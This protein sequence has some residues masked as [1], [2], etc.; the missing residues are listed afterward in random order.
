MILVP[1]KHQGEIESEIKSL[2]GHDARIASTTFEFLSIPMDEQTGTA[3]SLFS[4][5]H[6]II[7]DCIILSCDVVTN[8]PILNMINVYRRHDPSLVSL[9]C[10][11]NPTTM[12]RCFGSSKSGR[13]EKD[14]IG[15][16]DSEIHGCATSITCELEKQ[17][18]MVFFSSE[19]D[20]GQSIPFSRDMI[21]KCHDL[22][23]HSSYFDAHAYIFRKNVLD[24]L[25]KE[26]NIGSIKGEFIP[27][28]VQKQFQEEGEESVDN[29]SLFDK[30]ALSFDIGCSGLFFTRREGSSINCIANIIQTTNYSNTSS[31][32]SSSEV[33]PSIF[34]L[35]S[36]SLSGFIEANKR[37]A[38][39]ASFPSVANSPL[40]AKPRNCVNSLV[41]DKN[42]VVAV[43]AHVIRSVI[44]FNC[45]IGN[46][47]KITDSVVMD[48]VTVE[49][50]VVVQSTVI[51]SDAK[52]GKKSSLERC[53]VSSG[54]RV[55]PESQFIDEFL[56]DGSETEFVF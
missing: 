20:F 12:T 38:L 14:L 48:G 53:L 50:G 34:C 4:I 47:A 29:L 39:E 54:Y 52:I 27:H 2:G 17:K 37:I 40:T 22:S 36:N 33:E 56:A 9:I 13:G 31:H 5:R 7:T 3:D 18:R 1:D 55:H 41:S 51:C 45:V 44:G 28:L 32:N 42:T 26:R 11:L 19:S 24:L 10:T 16:D 49:D 46:S 43:N 6:R 25:F 21:T 35:R 15:F 30:T 8:Y 23:I